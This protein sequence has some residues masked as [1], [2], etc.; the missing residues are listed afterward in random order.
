MI[1]VWFRRPLAAALSGLAVAASLVTGAVAQERLTV[2]AA[3]SLKNALD[4]GDEDERKRRQKA[5]ISYAA[6][7]ALA[8]QIEGGAPADIFISADLRLD[9]LSF[10]EEAHQGRTPQSNCSAT[11]SSWSRRRIQARRV[12]IAP[13]FDLA[14]AARRRQA[15]HGRRQGGA[16]RQI[17]QGG[18]RKRSASGQRSRARSRRPRTCALR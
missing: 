15:R 1:S 17:R 14:G 8:K 13:D 18:A 5:T 3:A 16:G 12:D 7:S 11:A 4:G 9:G 2:F 10:R 6:S